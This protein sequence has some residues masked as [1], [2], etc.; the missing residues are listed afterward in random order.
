MGHCGRQSSC[1]QLKKH[2]QGWRP[3]LQA[4]PW[5]RSPLV[6]HVCLTCLTLTF[7]LGIFSRAASPWFWWDNISA[8]GFQAISKCH[9]MLN[10][11]W[12][13]YFWTFIFFTIKELNIVTHVG[14]CQRA[15]CSQYSS[16]VCWRLTKGKRKSIHRMCL[17]KIDSTKILCLQK[18]SWSLKP[19]WWLRLAL[20]CWQVG[21]WLAAI[22]W[23]SCWKQESILLATFMTSVSSPVTILS[24]AYSRLIG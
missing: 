8:A 23:K 13:S 22:A 20:C 15:T 7:I 6:L 11:Q 21:Y 16:Y 2:S 3:A 10:S 1:L 18:A 24:C 5:R 14:T 9:L 12:I 17:F 19:C 4:F